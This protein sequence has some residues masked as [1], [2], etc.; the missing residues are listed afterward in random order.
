[1]LT[2]GGAKGQYRYGP[3]LVDG[4]PALADTGS[5]APGTAYHQL[6]LDALEFAGGRYGAQLTLGGEAP[7]QI[8]LDLQGELETTVP[9]AAPAETAETTESPPATGNSDP[10][11][12]Q[13]TASARGTLSGADAVLDITAQVQGTAGSNTDAST[14]PALEAVAR[15][16]PWAPSPCSA[17]TPPRRHSIWPHSGRR[18]PPPRCQARC[19]PSPTATPGAPDST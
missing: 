15:V 7:L 11:K 13:A 5:T 3:G 1:V 10:I 12:L 8:A 9:G 14:V 19:G 16:M 6:V 17:P 18:P 4:T 2:L